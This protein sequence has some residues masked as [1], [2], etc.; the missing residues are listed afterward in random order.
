[1]P[2]FRTI[3][4]WMHLVAGVSA[5]VVVLVM[6][7]TGVL[8]TY[9][10]QMAFW[11][12]TRHMR[13]AP[14]QPGVARLPLDT[15]VDRLQAAKPSVAVQSITLR[16]NANEPASALLARDGTVY[17]DPYTGAILGTASSD[18]RAFFRTMTNWHRWLAM[19]GDYR[20]T[21][22]AITGAGNLI[23]LFIVLSGFYLWLPRVWRWVQFK[24]VLWFRRGLSSKA[25]DFN[26]HNVAGFWSAIPLAIVVASGSVISYPWASNLVYRALG[27]EPPPPAS[28]AAPAP[29]GGGARASGGGLGPTD[30]RAR[31]LQRPGV[32]VAAVGPEA[33]SVVRGTSAHKSG[34]TTN[35]GLLHHPATSGA[36]VRSV[37]HEPEPVTLDRLL[38]R[39]EQHVAGWRA[40]TLTLPKEPGVPVSFNIDRGNG[41]QPQ[42]RG[43]LTL[44]P[45][46]GAVVSWQPFASL[47]TGRRVRSVLRFA[48]TGEVLGFAGQTIA[49]LVS[50][51]TAVLVW[52]GMALAWRRMLRIWR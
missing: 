25:R 35:R 24:Q 43:T 44:D 15:L 45:V 20:A 9:E 11:A 36:D 30:E 46:S 5:G 34:I 6:S 17:V 51:A 10:K 2:R 52:T 29:A 3:L 8:L 27:E 23:F 40:I 1:M 19:T 31:I 4:F 32:V 41:G 39:A 7:V 26:W 50:L 47:S 22:R 38:A 49:G 14:P 13:V 33:N 28:R 48:H 18:L 12:E 21:G 16:S 42:L 37:A